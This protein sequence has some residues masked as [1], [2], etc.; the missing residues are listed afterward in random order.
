MTIQNMQETVDKWVS[1]KEHAVKYFPPFEMIAQLTEE[2]GEIAKEVAHLHGFK[3]K[4]DTEQTEGLE[5]EIGDL[6]FG[7]ICL[8]NSHGIYLEKAFEKTMEKKNNRD[9]ERFVKKN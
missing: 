9:A 2:L 5:S 4:K 8:A 6:L 7:I 3:K 1:K